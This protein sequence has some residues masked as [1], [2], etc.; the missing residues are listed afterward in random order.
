MPFAAH[1]NNLKPSP[2]SEW[3]RGL[4]N[5]GVIHMTAFKI[6]CL[7]VIGVAV[8]SIMASKILARKAYSDQN[9]KLT[10][11]ARIIEG[12]G[13]SIAIFALGMAIRALF[14]T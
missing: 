5:E 6:V 3:G 2:G 11:I 10:K 9:K 1:Y 4:K 8:V 7:S 14:F 12:V 13:T